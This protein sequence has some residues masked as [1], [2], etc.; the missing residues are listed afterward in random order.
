MSKKVAVI[1]VDSVTIDLMNE[2]H[3]WLGWYNNYWDDYLTIDQLTDYD[4]SKFVK[5]ECGDKIYDYLYMPGIYD[6]IPAVKDAVWGVGKLR[7]MGYHILYCT[8]TPVLN[9]DKG[10]ALERLGLFLDVDDYIEVKSRKGLNKS[11]LNGEF[12]LDDNYENCFH[13]YS[14]IGYL[15]TQPWNKMYGNYPDRVNGWKDFIGKLKNG[16]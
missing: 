13:F 4:V 8:F 14:G 3:G 11:F 7:E 9:G 16:S 15:F 5:P 12:L 6:I 2:T 1:D 10:R